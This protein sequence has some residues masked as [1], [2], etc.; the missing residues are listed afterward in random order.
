MLEP[1]ITT[2]DALEN[3]HQEF[4][5]DV[6]AGLEKPQKRLPSR[7]FYDSTG[8][9][10][11]EKITKL[12]EYYP[13]RTETAILQ[14]HAGD[15]ADR[16]GPDCLLVEYGA[17]ASVKTRILLDTLNDLVAYVPIDVSGDFLAETASGLRADYPSLDVL[18][19]T[20]DFMDP[21]DLGATVGK[22]GNPVGF[23]PGSTVGNLPDEDIIAFLATARRTLT[24]SGK[25]LVG[26]DLRKSPDILI[27]AYDDAAGVTAAF[28]L[29][30]LVRINR[31][32]GGR[33]DLATFTHQARWNEQAG[34]IEM[35][36]VSEIDQTVDLLGRSFPFAAGETIHTEI[37]RKF[38][39]SDFEALA[40][41]SGWVLDHCWFDP[42]AM[43]CVALLA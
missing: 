33:F 42:R 7:W 21:L 32:L 27:P 43:F 10:L 29:N 24:A 17:G 34:Q 41:R 19:I 25:F 4:A 8:S 39:I 23:F 28:N 40:V 3:E 26:V 11:F 22:K 35:H 38:R 2:L 14:S 5:Q 18:P 31:E 15:I 6:L 30:V 13:T 1:T 20:A 36:L 9:Q 12:P 16:L 37:S